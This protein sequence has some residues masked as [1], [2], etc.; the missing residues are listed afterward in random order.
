MNKVVNVVSV[1]ATGIYLYFAFGIIYDF[2]ISSLHLRSI[3]FQQEI[4]WM[5]SILVGLLGVLRAIRRWQGIAD[6]KK[7][8]SFSYNF[9]LSKSGFHFA[10]MHTL[11]EILFMVAT[12]I[13]AYNFLMEEAHNAYPIIGV[14]AVLLLESLLFLARRSKRDV[15]FGIGIN[16][17]VIALFNREMKL[18]YYVGLQR[19]EIHYDMIHFQY[20]GNLGMFL[21][22]K[23]IPEKNRIEFRDK[24]I[25]TLST[26]NVYI[27]EDFR[28]WQ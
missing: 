4:L 22:T 28:K 10:L 12:L 17:E 3:A 19:V 20:K 27:D 11:L 13:I 26:Q 2:S 24:L 21:P 8:K 23:M 14:A 25:E 5:L 1:I 7:F 16:K 9:K 6:M 18:Y 15:V